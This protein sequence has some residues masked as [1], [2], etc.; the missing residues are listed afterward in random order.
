MRSSKFALDFPHLPG[1][2]RCCEN[3]EMD[4]PQQLKLSCGDQPRYVPQLKF[5]VFPIETSLRVTQNACNAVSKQIHL[6]KDTFLRL[7]FWW[8]LQSSND[9]LE[10]VSVSRLQGAMAVG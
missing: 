7:L 6:Q 2:Y 9:R 5:A 1:T 8:W 4:M 10:R 3:D